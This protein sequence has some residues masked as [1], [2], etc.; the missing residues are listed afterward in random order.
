MKLFL[1]LCLSFFSLLTP[2]HAR[3]AVEYS[4][5]YTILIKGD[6]AG[7]EKVLEKLND[8]GQLVSTSE[9]EL[10]ITDGLIAKSMVFST[11]MVF[12][13]DRLDPVSYSYNYEGA[14]GD[15]C[16]IT[17]KEGQITRVLHKGGQTSEVTAPF[18]PGMVILDFNVYHQYDYL[19]RKYDRKKG[20]KQS[21]AD[22]IPVI[23]NDIAMIV[24]FAGDSIFKCS[25]G[26]LPVKKYGV[27]FIGYSGQILV[28]SDGRLVQLQ[29]PG[30]D[31]EVLRSD[32]FAK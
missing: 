13:K 27:E 25:K 24:T 21:F 29:I 11:K 12:S 31:L 4:Q 15:Y 8:S 7:H 9:H 2:T 23:G 18:R 20:G 32:L 6:V 14:T 17:I 30:Q 10:I 19:I 26:T 1:M 3:D 28:D 5:S 22:F 16:E